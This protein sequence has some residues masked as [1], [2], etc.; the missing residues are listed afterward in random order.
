[1]VKFTAIFSLVPKDIYNIQIRNYKLNVKRRNG[2]QTKN[3]KVKNIY[4]FQK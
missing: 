2:K 4:V 1:L 3:D